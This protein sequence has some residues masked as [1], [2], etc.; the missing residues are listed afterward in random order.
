M[1]S[2]R[3][4]HHA[5]GEPGTPSLA[6]SVQDRSLPHWALFHLLTRVSGVAPSPG[7]CRDSAGRAVP[8]RPCQVL[9]THVLVSAARPPLRSLWWPGQRQAPDRPPALPG[10][11]RVQGKA[12]AAARTRSR[13][14]AWWPGGRQPGLPPQ[15]SVR[16]EGT[17][18]R[19]AQRKKTKGNRTVLA[20][21]IST[22][23]AVRCSLFSASSGVAS[24]ARAF[25]SFVF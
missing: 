19:L 10:H 20:R 21:R 9:E 13:E 7:G 24:R 22:A 16:G 4:K 3:S 2:G 15:V 18:S 17:P 12:G 5:G 8:Q 23:H 14:G 1:T 6:R 25:Q 11:L